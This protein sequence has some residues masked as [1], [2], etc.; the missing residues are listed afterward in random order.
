[1]EATI[2]LL[3]CDTLN[4]G[5][6]WSFMFSDTKLETARMPNKMRYLH[7][8][9]FWRFNTI[10]CT[11]FSSL[12][13]FTDHQIKLSLCRLLSGLN[14]RLLQTFISWFKTG[15]FFFPR[16]GADMLFPPASTKYTQY[17]R[18]CIHNTQTNT[19]KWWQGGE[20]LRSWRW[21]EQHGSK[22]AGFFCCCLCL[23]LR[24]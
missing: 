2:Y 18:R 12:C 13:F 14:E 5:S 20:Q 11:V 3:K 1:M 22:L 23:R 10:L 21:E 4:Y 7:I 8:G 17:P 24:N 19:E 16:D 6:C 9:Q 15:R